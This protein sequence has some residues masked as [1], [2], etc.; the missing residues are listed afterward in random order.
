MAKDR[1]QTQDSSRNGAA[2]TTAE[3]ESRVAMLDRYGSML[4]GA[5]PAVAQRLPNAEDARESLTATAQ[6]AI[7][8]ARGTLNAALEQLPDLNLPDQLQ[9]VPVP[10]RKP[11]RGRLRRRMLIIGIAATVITATVL[12]LRRLTSNPQPEEIWGGYTPPGAPVE[13]PQAAGSNTGASADVGI[14]TFNASAGT[15]G[16]GSSQSSTAPGAAGSE[17]ESPGTRG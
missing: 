13:P 11:R 9:N 2:T 15:T 3:G 6:R 16:N 8:R 5:V 14:G 17:K 4:A 12:V 7:E 10:G 1:K